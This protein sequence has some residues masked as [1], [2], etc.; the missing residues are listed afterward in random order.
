MARDETVSLPHGQWT[1]LTGNDVTT[2]VSMEVR[3]GAV[4]VMA[5]VGANAPASS[6]TDG[7]EFYNVGDGFSEA[8]IAELWPGVSGADNLYGWPIS[9]SKAGDVALVRVSHG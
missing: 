2:D 5:T 1:R 9:T 4:R 3:K 8:T 7:F 6:V